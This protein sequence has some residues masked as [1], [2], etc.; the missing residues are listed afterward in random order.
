MK[1]YEQRITGKATAFWAVSH[2]DVQLYRQ[3]FGCKTISYLPLFLPSSWQ[4]TG[5]A[6]TGIYCLYQGKLEVE[7]NET[8]ALWLLHNV[9]AQLSVPFII[10]GK[11]PSSLLTKTVAS[12]SHVTLVANASQTKMEELISEA[13]IHVLPSFNATGIKIKLLNALYNGRHCLINS[14]AAADASLAS[15]CYIADNADS[16]KQMIQQLM[17]IPFSEEYIAQRKQLLQY[18]FNNA[19]NAVTITESL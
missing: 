4:V 6:G 5:K 3:Y 17:L 13:H 2:T 19:K 11:N 7:E 16:M 10:A 14:A 9:F 8:A 12:Y 18:E 1:K 15:L